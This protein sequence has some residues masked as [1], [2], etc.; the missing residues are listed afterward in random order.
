MDAAA[1]PSASGLFVAPNER[2]DMFERRHTLFASTALASLALLAA[3]CGGGGGSTN[4]SSSPATIKTQSPATVAVASSNLGNVLVDSH[5]RTLYLFGAD[6]GTKS[7]C[8][9]ECAQDWPPL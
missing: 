5:G 1:A 2:T 9:G 4:A 3:A 7:A 6:M 8:S